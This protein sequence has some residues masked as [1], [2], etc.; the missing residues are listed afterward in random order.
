M[1][2][3]AYSKCNLKMCLWYQF[4]SG[5]CNICQRGGIPTLR[6]NE[7]RDLTA[8]ILAETPSD[9]SAEPRLQPMHDKMLH[10]R[11]AN[12]DDEA[13]LDMRAS[14]FWC[15]GQETH[16]DRVFTHLT[17]PAKKTL[18]LCIT[19]IKARKRGNMPSRCEKWNVERSTPWFLHPLEVWPGSVPR[20]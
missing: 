17:P 12:R 14:D 19:G 9:I 4:F 20:F 16:F 5:P 15:K 7:I 1:I 10:L 6:H 8:E 3:M 13:R 2:W 18:P 11:S